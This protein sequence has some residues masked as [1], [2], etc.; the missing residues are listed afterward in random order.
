M[1]Q[2]KK[3]KSPFNKEGMFNEANP[4]VFELA[5]ELRRNMTDAE[6]ILWNCLKVGINGLKFRRQHPI[7]I[8]IADF[9]CHKI[10]LVIE[11]D[12]SM[13]NKKEIKEFDERRENDLK[14]WGYNVIRFSNEHVLKERESA[15][16]QIHST[17]EM[18]SVSLKKL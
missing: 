16:A 14:N 18:L 11:V 3:N 4:L 5:K 10:K 12:G 6:I 7:G 1:S 17:V 2:R 9:Y 13:H 8:Y 15:L